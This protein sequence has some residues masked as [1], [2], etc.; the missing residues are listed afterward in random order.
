MGCRAATRAIW[1][2]SGSYA[3][4]YVV[5]LVCGLVASPTALHTLKPQPRLR[6]DD[7]SPHGTPP[8]QL[9]HATHNSS[10]I[11]LILKLTNGQDFLRPL[12]LELPHPG[13]DSIKYRQAEDNGPQTGHASSGNHP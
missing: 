5:L 8:A 10:R 9:L 2:E 11:Y 3:L 12:N 4:P 1:V 6:A 13:S 7:S